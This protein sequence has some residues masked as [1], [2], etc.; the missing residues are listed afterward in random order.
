[1]IARHLLLCLVLALFARATIAPAAD[2]QPG[3]VARL[4]FR[5]VDGNDL[6]TADGRVTILTVATRESEDKAQA[7]ADLV[8]DRYVGDQRYRYI[9]LVNFQRKLAAPL[10]GLTRAI[11]RQ[12]LDAEAKKLKP[13]YEAKKIA[14]DPRRDIYVVADFDGSAV[15]QL[16]LAP[17]SDEVA[18]FVFN[19]QGKLIQHWTDVPP[20]DSLARAIAAAE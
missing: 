1:M 6:S 4:T 18:V 9:T 17:E 7:V 10:R 2:L 19:R 3:T 15:T 12:R 8:P 20:N 13:E 5:D 16:G 14:H 11:I